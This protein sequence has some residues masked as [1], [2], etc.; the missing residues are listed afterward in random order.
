MSSKKFITKAEFGELSKVMDYVDIIRKYQISDLLAL[1]SPTPEVIEPNPNFS[2]T[3]YSG[4]NFEKY[5]QNNPYRILG[6]YTDSNIKKETDKLIKQVSNDIAIDKT[7]LLN[8]IFKDPPLDEHTIR[9]NKTKI[10][11]DTEGIYK[12]YWLLEND[13]K[14]KSALNQMVLNFQNK[15]NTNETWSNLKNQLAEFGTNY[16]KLCSEL[17]FLLWWEDG[18]EVYINPSETIVKDL[19][20]AKF[21]VQK[22]KIDA[23][24]KQLNEKYDY[25]PNKKFKLRDLP[26][27]GVIELE[28]DILKLQNL[29]QFGVEP[30]FTINKICKFWNDLAVSIYNNVN[31]EADRTV[32]S[33]EQVVKILTISLK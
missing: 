21:G 5:L 12:K 16:V 10:D 31:T 29:N 15:V 19:A 25:S 8:N 2:I 4:T 26:L 9:E 30:E 22:T 32:E 11:K 20:K 27:V 14:L 1:P 13:E 18:L 23:K 7:I 3:D 17:C 6:L 24:I 28:Q 33:C